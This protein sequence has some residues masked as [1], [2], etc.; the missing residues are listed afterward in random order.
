M[1]ALEMLA[2]LKEIQTWLRMASI[3]S[4]Y[5]PVIQALKITDE[6]IAKMTGRSTAK[7]GAAAASEGARGGLS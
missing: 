4:H 5:E 6:A 3:D 1:T 2:T 7:N